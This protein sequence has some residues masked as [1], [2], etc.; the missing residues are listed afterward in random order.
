MSATFS[1]SE[2]GITLI[3]LLVTLSIMG[4]IMV[5]L[6]SALFIGMHTTRDTNTS[7][8][9]SNTEQLVSRWLAHDVQGADAVSYPGVSGCGN[10]PVALQAASKSDPL[11]GA[12]DTT[13]IY[14]LSGR[15]L[16]RQVCG[17]RPSTQTLAR[18]VTTFN[19]SGTNVVTVSVGTAA[20][21]SVPAYSWS[22][23]LRRRRA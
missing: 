12:S 8:D 2:A 4:I 14:R 11:A 17:P 9:Q 7:L 15:E 10:R 23:E 13:V 18:D 19:A 5:A 3:E 20:S 21:A 1:R 16:V 6:T 22:V